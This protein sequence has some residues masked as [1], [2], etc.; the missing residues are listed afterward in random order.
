M[1]ERVVIES[2]HESIFGGH[3]RKLSES[4]IDHRIDS[5]SILH[6]RHTSTST[7]GMHLLLTK[8]VLKLAAAEEKPLRSI[9][10]NNTAIPR[11]KSTVKSTLF[12]L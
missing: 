9:F 4:I 1:S 3:S 11:K 12:L 8:F 10:P 6:P 7:W 5:E 2:R